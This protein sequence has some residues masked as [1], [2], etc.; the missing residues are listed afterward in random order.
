MYV[1]VAGNGI[2]FMDRVVGSYYRNLPS[3][4]DDKEQ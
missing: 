4:P 3:R 1:F 2:F